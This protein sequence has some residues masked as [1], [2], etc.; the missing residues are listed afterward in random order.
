MTKWIKTEVTKLY[1]VLITQNYKEKNG[2]YVI[3]NIHL[4]NYV[5]IHGHVFSKGVFLFEY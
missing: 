4:F 1:V 2:T 5:C 3:K